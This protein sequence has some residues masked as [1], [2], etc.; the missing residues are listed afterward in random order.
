MTLTDIAN[1]V[2]EDLGSKSIGNIDGDDF[3]AKRIKRR[4]YFSIETI[5][6]RR[7]WCD[8]RKEVKLVAM[9]GKSVQGMFRFIKPK[10]LLNILD[11]SHK[12]ENGGDC[13]LCDSQDLQIY[14]TIV[15]FNPND[16]GVNLR[17]AIIAQLKKDLAYPI[18]NDGNLATN[19]L[20]LAE[21][22]IQEA[23]LHD[24]YDEKQ[25][26]IQDRPTWFTGY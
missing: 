26:V 24:A 1:I 11:G 25:R 9:A 15:S 23:M 6:K 18:T 3:D 7:N 16:W 21:R 19:V 12:W 13:L 22:D 8:L 20:Q 10:G 2:L 5:S 4:I 14:C 17:N